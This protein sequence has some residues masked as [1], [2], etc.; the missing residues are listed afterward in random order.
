MNSRL[1]FTILIALLLVFGTFLAIRWA[2]G[3]RLNL[4]KKAVQGTGLLVANSDPQGASV[5]INDELKTATDDTLHLS[6]G[7]YKIRLEKDGFAPWEKNIR[8]EK[9]LVSQTNARLFP[10]VPNLSALTVNSAQNPTPSPD[11]NKIAF[12]IAT[13]SA[14]TK[15]GIWVQNLSDN[16]LKGSSAIQIAQDSSFLQFSQADIFWSPN[17]NEIIAYFNENSVYILKTTELNKPQNLLNTAFQLP[18]MIAEWQNQLALEKNKKNLKL[19]K[20]MQQIA[21]SSATLT[22]FSPNEE[23]LLYIATESVKL[24]DNLIPPLP[25]INSQPQNRQLEPNNIYVYDLKEDTNFLIKKNVFNIDQL[26]TYIKNFSLPEIQPEIENQ[27]NPNS[28]TINPESVDL[29]KFSI[30]E[31]LNN[32]QMHYSPIYSDLYF[33]WFPN[34]NHLIVSE[35]N[36]IS[37]IEYDS[38]NKIS[39][40]YA[41]YTENFTYPWPNGDKL[42]ILTSLSSNPDIPP[43]LYSLSL[44]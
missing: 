29:N 24:K 33:Q 34:S 30:F 1:L 44:K 41:D 10:S 6:P 38:T 4:S 11:G 27:S 28:T 2:E 15:Y 31:Y 17:S 14:Q 5:Y 12:K 22:Y 35:P 16:L 32:L 42:I 37:I 13:G 20:Q 25:A 19:P 18:T 36:N 26:Q 9:E 21:T 39:V 40:F 7:N 43:N 8:I 23:K 3:Y